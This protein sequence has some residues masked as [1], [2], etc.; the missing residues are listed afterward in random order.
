MPN[1]QLE[2]V[3]ATRKQLYL[4]EVKLFKKFTKQKHWNAYCAATAVEIS[5]MTDLIRMQFLALHARMMKD[6]HQRMKKRGFY[7]VSV[8][9]R[10]VIQ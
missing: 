2:T 4:V 7:K 8:A 10:T 6:K 5:R 3:V 9:K 1:V